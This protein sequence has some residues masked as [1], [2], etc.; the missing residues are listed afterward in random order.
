LVRLEGDAAHG[1][2]Q[3]STREDPPGLAHERL[4]QGELS[5]GKGNL[6]LSHGDSA[7]RQIDDD[8]ERAQ[9]IPGRRRLLRAAE[10]CAN[11][12]DELLG[13]EWLHDV[14]V[15]PQVEADDAIALVSASGEHHDRDFAEA[16]QL[17]GDVESVAIGKPEVEDD[18]RRR[19]R[20]RMCD[21]ISGG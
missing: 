4:K 17:A 21:G 5:R 1:V 12:S 16:P 15:R 13:A 20:A 2:E 11:T 19:A 6:P 9:L 3:L 10:N 14:V 18:E 7:T 8:V